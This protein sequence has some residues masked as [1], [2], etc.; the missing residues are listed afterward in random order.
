M[1]ERPPRS[2]YAA[3]RRSVRD[4]RHAGVAVVDDQGC[5]PGRRTSRRRWRGK[6]ELDRV[7]RAVTD[8]RGQRW[9][10]HGDDADKQGGAAGHDATARADRNAHD[11]ATLGTLARTGFTR[12]SEPAHL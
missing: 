9:G 8:R 6:A 7:R 11:A 10:G 4:H 3:A 12:A 1:L 2:L 5:G